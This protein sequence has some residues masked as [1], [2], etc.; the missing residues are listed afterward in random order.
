[1]IADSFLVLVVAPLAHDALFGGGVAGGTARGGQALRVG[2]EPATRTAASVNSGTKV[3]DSGTRMTNSD[4]QV[5]T[6]GTKDANSGTK[7]VNSGTMEI[8]EGIQNVN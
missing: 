7:V 5:V 8:N 1:M 6:S 2:I 3:V 4:T